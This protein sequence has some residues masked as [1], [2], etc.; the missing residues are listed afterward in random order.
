MNNTQLFLIIGVPS[1]LVL[2][3]ILLDQLGQ[4]RVETRLSS[5]EG[6]LRQFWIDPQFKP[7]KKRVRRN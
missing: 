2:V 4:S 5:I 3:G 6:G 7:T 1:F